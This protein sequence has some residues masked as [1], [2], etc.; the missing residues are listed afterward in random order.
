[1]PGS[2]INLDRHRGFFFASFR[3]FFCFAADAFSILCRSRTGTR[4]DLGFPTFI[5]MYVVLDEEEEESQKVRDLKEC[6][7]FEF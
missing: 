2:F 3:C 5:L 7:D 4:L 6:Q 1:M